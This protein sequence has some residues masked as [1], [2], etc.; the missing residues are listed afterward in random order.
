MWFVASRDEGTAGADADDL[1]SF[2][3]S[4]ETELVSSKS[5]VGATS[6]VAGGRSPT[7][8]GIVDQSEQASPI[9]HPK[10]SI[11]KLSEKQILQMAAPQFAMT[12]QLSTALAA[13]FRGWLSELSM[14]EAS[15][16]VGLEL[17]QQGYQRLVEVEA[18]YNSDLEALA[19]LY[20][21]DYDR[22]LQDI[23]VNR[24]YHFEEPLADG[25]F[26]AAL[27]SESRMKFPGKAIYFTIDDIRY[28][29]LKEATDKRSQL[30][31]ERRM[32]IQREVARM[33]GE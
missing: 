9:G 10:D 7:L 14:K 15:S 3:R 6:P 22:A 29:Q 12:P 17:D 4:S 26:R 24:L 13:G 20:I 18:P 28:P 8:D 1:S 27:P 19:D 21:G 25:T 5:P 11:G 2:E 23:W 30:I 32:A 16:R 33:K 31:R